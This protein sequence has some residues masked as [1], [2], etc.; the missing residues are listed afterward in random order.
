MWLVVH[1]VPS[2]TIENLRRRARELDSQEARFPTC[3]N[4]SCQLLH[5]AGFRLGEGT[6]VPLEN[7]KF[8]MRTF[9]S[10]AYDGLFLGER[11]MKVSVIRTAP[12][13]TEWILKSAVMAEF[14]T[15]WRHGRRLLPRS[16]NKWIDNQQLKLERR[17][18]RKPMAPP[19]EDMEYRGNLTLKISRPSRLARYLRVLWG[20]H[21]VFTV[22]YPDDIRI[23]NYFNED[24]VPFG[25][26]SK[27]LLTR[28]KR[29]ILFSPTMIRLYRSILVD[30][31][32]EFRNVS[33]SWICK[34]LLADDV[35]N[36][37]IT[38][39]GINVARV[40]IRLGFVD[41]VPLQAFANF[42]MGT[43]R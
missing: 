25:N 18:V 37:V 17:A 2:D 40:K 7:R 20:S 8:P 43:Q 32:A 27:N 33:E 12:S 26:S 4:G 42:R 9:L 31:Y 3:V 6:E 38:D 13:S 41:C 35:C 36:Y 30:S 21:S 15:P 22:E 29:N 19:L 5:S 14:A 28:L 23:Y 34:M 39:E 24:L 10:M 11:E 16:I 1:D